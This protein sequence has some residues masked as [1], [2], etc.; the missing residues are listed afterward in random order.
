MKD[1]NTVPSSKPERPSS[2]VGVMASGEE[3][4]S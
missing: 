4:T 3:T 1:A 2:E